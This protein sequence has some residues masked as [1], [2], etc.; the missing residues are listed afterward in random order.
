[1]KAMKTFAALLAL[2]F[3]LA[4]CGGS[5]KGGSPASSASKNKLDGDN[6]IASNTQKQEY[7]E[8]EDVTYMRLLAGED[9]YRACVLYLGGSYEITTDVQKVLD[10]Q[11]GLRELW[12]FVYDIPQDHW[13]VAPDGGCDLYCIFPQ[14]AQATLFVYET[15][16]TDDAENP[17]QRGKQLYYS[18]DGQPILLLCNISVIVPNTEVELYPSTGEEL[19]F[20]PFLSGENGHVVEA[21]GVCDFTIYP[22][23]DDWISVADPWSLEGNWLEIA[24][25]TD[26]GYFETAPADADAMCFLPTDGETEG[27]QLPLTASYITPYPELNVEEADLFYHEGTPEVPFQTNQEWY[28]TFTGEDGSRYAVTLEDENTLALKFYLEGEESYMSLVSTVYFAR[29]EAMG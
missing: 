11:Q 12:G 9:E 16:L 18:E 20:S 6:M 13:V 23:G 3:S 27:D 10:S 14:E 4:G 7:E 24:R 19:V 28:A 26:E 22:E 17:L 15:S 5:S 2:A 29:Q 1:M 8:P 21:E 25:D